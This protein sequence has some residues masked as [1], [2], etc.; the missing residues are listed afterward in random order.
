MLLA[1]LLELIAP[2]RCAG[3]DLPG[4]VICPECV[5][6]LVLTD[7]SEA[8]PRC[9][10]PRNRIACPD[11]EGRTFGFSAAMSAGALEPPL[12][13][14]VTLYKDSGERRYA[15]ILCAL[16]SDAAAPWHGWPD[17]VVPI[18]PTRSARV[19][20]GF[21]HTLPLARAVGAAVG[22]PVECRLAV[23]G[24]RDQRVLGRDARFAN[25]AGAFTVLGEDPVPARVLLV[26]DVM[27]TGATLEA[28]SRALLAAGAVE[29]RVVVLARA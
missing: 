13:R 5:A 11:C 7:A 1:G 25:M 6:S 23:S 3:C 24:R 15:A 10:A 20:R 19:R 22:A 12:S 2:P 8:C 26:D 17:V 14:A 28:A 21:D 27:T 29:V 4:S 18:P 16:L 9:G